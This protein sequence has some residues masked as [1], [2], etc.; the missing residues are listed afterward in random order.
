MKIQDIV[1]ALVSAAITG[2]LM[3]KALDVHWTFAAVGALCS[4]TTVI[5]LARRHRD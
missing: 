1:Y 5:A 3:F 4:A 2:V